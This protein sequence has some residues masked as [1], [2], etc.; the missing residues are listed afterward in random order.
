MIPTERIWPEDSR[1]F[2]RC[3]KCGLEFLGPKRAPYCYVCKPASTEGTAGVTDADAMRR[4]KELLK[5]GD[6]RTSYAVFDEATR[7]NDAQEV[8]V[9][10]QDVK[11]VMDKYL[12]VG[13]IDSRQ[14]DNSKPY[15]VFSKRDAAVAVAQMVNSRFNARKA[16]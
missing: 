11:A 8:L 12:H 7:R 10:W 14:G 6:A 13:Q 3:A 4:G 1:Y 5:A 15:A 16:K 9:T 2:G